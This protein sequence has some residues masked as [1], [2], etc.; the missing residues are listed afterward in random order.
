MP[1]DSKIT[2][3]RWTG[4]SVGV[5]VAVAAVFVILVVGPSFLSGTALDR[6]TV[7]FIYVCLAAMW[8]ALAGYGGMISAGQQAFFGL[9]GYLAIRLSEWGVEPYLALVAAAL[10]AGLA[11]L[12][13]SAIVLRLR[14]GEFAIGMWVVA[15]VVRLL[16]NLDPIIQGDTGRSLIALSAFDAAQRRD[17]TYWIALGSMSVMLAVIFFMLRSRLGS[18]IQAIRDNEEAA[19]SVGVKVAATKRIIFMTAAVGCALAGG[20]WLATFTTFQPRSFFSIQWSAY[21]IFMVLVG[22]IGRFEGPIL[23]A[24]IF[25]FIEL[26]FGS[27]GVWYLIVLG[28]T[29]LVFSLFLPKGIWG[30]V[31]DR[32]H[33]LLLPVGYR[34]RT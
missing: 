13:I 21:M 14:A 26:W 32:F 23:G 9:G 20:L 10:L 28:L 8:N 22:G 24:I 17:F 18:S 3:Q 6:L 1:L 30:Y 12:P 4:L 19:A 27:A 25:F 11:A 2:I 7:L 33:V 31:E 16:V 5:A 34:V 29:A 15:E